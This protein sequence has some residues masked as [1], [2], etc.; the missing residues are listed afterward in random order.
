LI[1]NSPAEKSSTRLLRQSVGLNDSSDSTKADWVLTVNLDTGSSGP[2]GYLRMLCGS[3]ERNLLLDVNVLISELRPA[4]SK[5][6]ELVLSALESSF[7]ENVIL[8]NEDLPGSLVP[9]GEEALLN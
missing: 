7:A 3:S 6:S 1:P 5:V 9:A 2:L 4:L 8:P